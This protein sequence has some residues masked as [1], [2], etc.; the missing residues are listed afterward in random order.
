M[1]RIELIEK[2]I[3]EQ[4]HSLREF[5]EKIKELYFSMLNSSEVIVTGCGDSYAASLML[6]ELV[7]VRAEDPY[8][9]SLKEIHNPLV[10]VSVSGKTIANINLAE[11]AKKKGLKIY[12]ITGNPESKLAKLADYLI[13]IEYKEP[14]VLPGTLSFTKSLIALYVAFGLNVDFSK[15]NEK[16]IEKAFEEFEEAKGES[17]F[18]I[19]SPSYFPLSIYWKAKLIEMIGSKVIVERC[20]QFMHMDLFAL[21][22]NDS[23]LILGIEDRRCRLL[24]DKIKNYITYCKYEVFGEKN[25][26]NFLIGSIY[27]QVLAYSLLKRRNLKDVHFSISRLLKVS[28]ELIY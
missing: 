19:S 20:E 18:I 6:N 12:V 4:A 2:E 10:I 27:G 22:E 13:D 11:K 1:N 24:Y 16:L 26:T 8:E 23:V 5:Y 21:S 15:I 9:L 25:P 28:D 17:F 14:I 7:G 3:R